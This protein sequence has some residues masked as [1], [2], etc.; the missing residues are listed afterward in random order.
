MREGSFK[1]QRKQCQSG[2]PS[3]PR[4]RVTS[5]VNPS[6]LLFSILPTQWSQWHNGDTRLYG[7]VGV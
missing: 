6:Q 5:F 3:T 7:C 1:I 4:H 2:V